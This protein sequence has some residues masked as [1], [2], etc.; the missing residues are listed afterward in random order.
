MQ[1][2]IY[3]SHIL[4]EATPSYANKSPF[5]MEKRRSM[6]CGDVANDSYLHMSAHLGT[7]VDMPVHFHQ[8]AQS[9]VHYEA[10]FWFFNNPIV[11]EVKPQGLILY[12][13]IIEQL[14]TCAREQLEAC[15]ILI[16]KTNIE[17][18]RGNVAFWE[19]NPG[20]SP[21][22]YD[23]FKKN[24]PN[25]RILGFDSISLSSYQ[26]RDIGREAHQKFLNPQGPILPLE[27]MKL[28]AINAHTNFQKIVVSPLRIAGCDGLPCTV[29]GWCND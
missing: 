4:D 1:K 15:D 2:I 26:N 11:I 16:V 18:K 29:L 20:F 19:E 13:E 6:C 8:D 12:D 14:E 21:A 24:I 28:D 7:H 25:L 27:D 5:Q 10:K 9:I 17:L 3:L 23:Y 22:L